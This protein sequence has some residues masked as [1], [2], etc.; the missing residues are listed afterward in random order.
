[1][2]SAGR[3]VRC[4]PFHVGVGPIPWPRLTA[5]VLLPAPVNSHGNLYAA[6]TVLTVSECSDQG[7]ATPTNQRSVCRPWPLRSAR[8]TLGSRPGLRNHSHSIRPW[9]V[10]LAG[11]PVPQGVHACSTCRSWRANSGSSMH[12]FTCEACV[13]RLVFLRRWTRTRGLAGRCVRR[14]AKGLARPAQPRCRAY[15]SAMITGGHLSLAHRR[16]RCS[17]GRDRRGCVGW[18]STP[19]PPA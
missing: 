16:C 6:R 10:R 11:A 8:R 13:R 12:R 2:R 19:P 14:V 17:Q 4:S 18:P 1:L 5:D 9:C 3:D 15:A 7:G